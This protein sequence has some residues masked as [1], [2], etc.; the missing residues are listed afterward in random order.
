MDVVDK[1]YPVYGESPRQ[2]LITEQGD[3]YLKAKFP[4]IDKIKMARIVPAAPPASSAPPAAKPAAK[5][6]PK[7]SP[8]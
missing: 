2:E 7:P 1:I 4:D 3:A 5:P 6:S 8:Q